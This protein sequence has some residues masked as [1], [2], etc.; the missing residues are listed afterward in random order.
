MRSQCSHRHKGPSRGRWAAC[1]IVMT[2]PG[3]SGPRLVP[4]T[5]RVV[6]WLRWSRAD[7]GCGIIGGNE[8]KPW[9]LTQEESNH[10]MVSKT[11]DTGAS[12]SARSLLQPPPSRPRR[13][14]WQI[15]LA[16]HSSWAHLHP[17]CPYIM[18]GYDPINKP[19]VSLPSL[20][21]GPH[22]GRPPPATRCPMPTLPQRCTHTRAHKH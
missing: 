18:T 16:D 12:T 4:R 8:L 3:I 2:G 22:A 15:K 20:R 9:I 11:V 10:L 14:D 7:E 19:R 1:A 5:A 6:P 13:P 21:R 17:T